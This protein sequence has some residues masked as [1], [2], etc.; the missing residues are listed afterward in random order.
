[1]SMCSPSMTFSTT[2]SRHQRD[3]SRTAR[4]PARTRSRV[5]YPRLHA[6][7]NAAASTRETSGS[8]LRR[9]VL[10]A[11]FSP[12]NA[13]R[14][15]QNLEPFRRGKGRRNTCRAIERPM[16]AS[17]P[18]RACS[19][20]F[21]RPRPRDGVA[22]LAH[23]HLAGRSVVVARS[24]FPKTHENATIRDA[25]QARRRR[26]CRPASSRTTSPMSTNSST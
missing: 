11:P 13:M 6:Y 24:R 8:Q 25:R 9:V 3:A 5:A 4:A 16:Q 2:E 21:R 12:I 20:T 23:D 19:R 10:P 14:A 26:A 18:C 15:P 17:P 22:H 1:M 7:D